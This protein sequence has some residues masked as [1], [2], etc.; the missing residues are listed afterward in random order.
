[1]EKIDYNE[2]FN[3]SFQFIQNTKNQFYDL[4]YE[5]FISN[6]PEIKNKFKSV[7][8]TKQKLMLKESIIHT[9]Q[10]SFNKIAEPY[11]I[12][13]AQ[14]HYQLNIEPYMF[15]LFMEAIITALSQCYPKFDN[16]CALA[17]RIT[18][19]PGLEFMKYF[20]LNQ[21]ARA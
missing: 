6:S 2:I 3:D 8:L 20:C 13:I 12:K 9:V 18:L 16:H 15:N 11:L 21:N 19:S 4:F 1:M 5:N 14:I 10:F 7:D 17:W